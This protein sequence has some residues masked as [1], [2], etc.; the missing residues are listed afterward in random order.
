MLIRYSSIV[1]LRNAV[2]LLQ[3]GDDGCTCNDP[4]DPISHAEL[5]GWIKTHKMNMAQ[6]DKV[7][8]AQKVIDVAF[9]GD[10]I[11]EEWNGR[12]VGKN[13]PSLTP[14]KKT[15]DKYFTREGGG[16]YEGVALGI[17]GDQAPHVL[18]RLKHGEIPDSFKPRVWWLLA[19]INDL[20]NGGCSPEVVLLGILR[21]V[22][23]IQYWKPDAI[24]VINSI[25]PTAV[26]AIKRDKNFKRGFNPKNENGPK[27]KGNTQ[28]K[29][30]HNDGVDENAVEDPEETQKPKNKFVRGFTQVKDL[31]PTIKIINKQLKKF[32][33]KHSN[34]QYFEAEDIFITTNQRG[35]TVINTKLMNGVHPTPEGHKEWAKKIVKKL[36]GLIDKQKSLPAS[37]DPPAAQTSKGANDV[38]DDEDDA[39]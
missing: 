26:P 24:I 36:E 30:K 25:L 15:F 20:T 32:S 1:H 33:E 38:D 22:E 2:F 37:E 27:A 35:K 39:Y 11:T 5:P 29:G 10:S 17:A 3:G 19:G 9:L 21:I 7:V 12:W 23:E 18:W 28:K 16:D 14:I 13:N 6:I 34:I 8:Q 4:L 31:G